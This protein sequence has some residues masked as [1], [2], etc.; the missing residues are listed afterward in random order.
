MSVSRWKTSIF[1]GPLV[2]SVALLLGAF[3]ASPIIMR[4]DR[5]ESRYRDLGESY[6]PYLVQLGLPDRE[7]VPRLYGGM[8]TLIA[9][10]WVVTAGHTADRFTAQSDYPVAME[11]HHVWIMGR[12]YRVRSVH[13][14]PSYVRHKADQ[15]IALLELETAPVNARSACLYGKRDERGCQVINVGAGLPGNGLTGE[16]QPDGVVRGG[17]ATVDRAEDNVLIW[18]FRTPGSAGV[19][20]LEGISGAGD[21]GGPAFVVDDGQVCI[22]GVSGSQRRR[23]LRRQGTYGVDEVYARVSTYRDW[24]TGVIDGNVRTDLDRSAP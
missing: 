12:G 14:H 1:R 13:L 20:D 2:G 23:G 11:G 21:S 5:E 8:V 10:T 15:D 19:S 22:A 3:S 7:G 18:R 16:G 4:H 6:R 24:I 17:T 9:P